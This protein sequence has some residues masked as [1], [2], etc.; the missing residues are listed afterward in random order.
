MNY[1]EVLA[2]LSRLGN[3]VQT[4]KFGLDTT[5]AIL[6]EL[7][8]PQ[9]SFPSIVV[10]G[11]NGKGSVSSFIHQCLVASGLRAGI[12]TSPHLEKIEERFKIGDRM[13]SK[14]EFADRFSRV[15]EAALSLGLAS[16]PTFFELITCTALDFFALQ[17]ADAA[18]LEVGMG[19]RLDSTNVVDPVLSVITRISRDH[20]QYL[21][22]TLTL[23][24]R[25]KAGIFR[26]GVP[27]VSAEQDPEAVDALQKKASETGTPLVFID[28]GEYRVTGSR[29][30]YYSFEY[31]GRNFYLGVPG[32]H[33]VGNA[34]LALRSLG[35]L[36]DRGWRLKPEVFDEG[37]AGMRRLGVVEI[38][39]SHP[40]VILDGGHN[41]DAARQLR[42][43]LEE[44][45]KQPLTLVF[46][47]MK[48]KD[49]Q[50]VSEAL[51][52]LFTEIF[53]VSISSGRAFKAEEMKRF[54]PSGIVMDS[55][56]AGLE[57]AIALGNPVVVAGSFYLAG[58]V[59]SRLRKVSRGLD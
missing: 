57:A 53:L 51:S 59:R 36:G 25:E 26:R 45:Y 4:M 40:E 52:P 5:R 13:I 1:S 55:A 21:G 12:F 11:T 29:S 16:H 50:S 38:I 23:I 17:K 46:G 9:E 44:F 49:I 27:A 54:F 8:R 58:E 14:E 15:L 30:G 56:G 18:V 48:D 43:F 20:Q 28:P 32:I 19:G 33:Q 39:D 10:A 34:A 42:A 37:I 41:P 22:D 3:E 47:M 7:G 35:M 31:Q 6:S 24:A 2:Y